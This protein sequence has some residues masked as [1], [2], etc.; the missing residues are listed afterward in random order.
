MR[1][2]VGDMVSV[3]KDNHVGIVIK[4]DKANS[5]TLSSSTHSNNLVKNSTDIYYIL[6]PGSKMSGPY[7][8]SEL[9]LK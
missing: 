1:F 3:L 8:A 2:Q 5:K 4:A 9:V 6:L 7:Y